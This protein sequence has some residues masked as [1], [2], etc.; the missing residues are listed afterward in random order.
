[1][2][3]RP[4]VD[5]AEVIVR[6]DACRIAGLFKGLSEAYGIGEHDN[7]ATTEPLERPK[8]LNLERIGREGVCGEESQVRGGA[9]ESVDHV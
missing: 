6:A 4:S 2:K 8:V 1:M 5:L 3:G 9:V 7:P